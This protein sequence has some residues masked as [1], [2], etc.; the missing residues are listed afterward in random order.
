MIVDSIDPAIIYSTNP[1]WGKDSED[2]LSYG[3][4]LSTSFIRGA[5]LNFSFDGTGIWYDCVSHAI[6]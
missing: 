1:G 6:Q 2:I 4:S 5:S 3:R